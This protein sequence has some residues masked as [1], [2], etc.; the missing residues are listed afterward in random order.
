M[1]LL[2]KKTMIRSVSFNARFTWDYV[3]QKIWGKQVRR[4]VQLQASASRR[5]RSNIHD[6]PVSSWCNT[7]LAPPVALNTVGGA[8]I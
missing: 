5:L 6:K 7:A 3:A 4:K 1:K 2:E 8:K